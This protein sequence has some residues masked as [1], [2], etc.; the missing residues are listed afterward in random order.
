M[1]TVRH[2]A[3]AERLKYLYCFN[4]EW[5]APLRRVSVSVH[6]A[7]AWQGHGRGMAG[8][9]AITRNINV[10]CVQVGPP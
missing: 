1:G 7:G 4:K 10:L 2:I 3:E 8:A 6:M 9:T 5:I